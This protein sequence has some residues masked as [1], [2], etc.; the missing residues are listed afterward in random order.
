MIKDGIEI[1]V[2][3]KR[4]KNLYIRITEDGKVNI[5][6]PLRLSDKEVEKFTDEKLAWIK[7]KLA[8]RKPKNEAA[9]SIFGNEYEILFLPSAHSE[10]KLENGKLIVCGDRETAI[11]ELYKKLLFEKL[12]YITE[13]AERR[14]MK[15]AS[16]WKIRKMKTRWGSC[17]VKT[18]EITLSSNLA[19]FPIKCAVYVATHELCHLCEPSHNA[20]FK[21]LVRRFCENGDECEKMLKSEI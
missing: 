5:S 19:K 4:I 11:S 6:V 21:S 14:T 10:A 18:A 8:K 15:K 12:S 2:T 16:K 3:K 17:N 1:N 20:R 13:E 9:A 7:S